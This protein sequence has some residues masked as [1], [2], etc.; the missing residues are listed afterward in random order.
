MSETGIK[1]SCVGIGQKL[2][3]VD[4]KVSMTIVMVFPTVVTWDFTDFNYVNRLG[5]IEAGGNDTK[6]S[7]LK[8]LDF[9]SYCSIHK[10]LLGTVPRHDCIL[11][12]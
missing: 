3:S 6:V 9:Q 1:P 10:Q 8:H 12:T 5:D 11:R 7:I 2:I 4:Q